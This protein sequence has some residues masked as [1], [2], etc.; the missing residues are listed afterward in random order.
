MTIQE[1][2][3]D[4]AVKIPTLLKNQ[5]QNVPNELAAYIS[6]HMRAGKNPAP[7]VA[8]T[9]NDAR[10][11][12]N[13]GA[14]LKAASVPNATGNISETKITNG[15]I[16]ITQGVDLSVIP[17][18]RIHEY[19]GQAGRGLKSTIPARP[20]IGPA[21]EQYQKDADGFTALVD[22]IMQDIME[23]FK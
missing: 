1:Y 18:A 20:Y 19:G 12:V 4:L 23:N 7:R 14:L 8:R 21:I 15:E 6:D 5:L 11:Y 9:D 13:S 10:L 16:V 22:E 17:Y 2:I 3:R